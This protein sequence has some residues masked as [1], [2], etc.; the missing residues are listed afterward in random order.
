MK[1]FTKLFA[2]CALCFL[3]NSVFAKIIYVNAANGAAAVKDGTTWANAY[4]DLQQALS[5]VTL[6]AGDEIWVA[7]GVYK[8][9]TILGA[10]ADNRDKTFVLKEGVKV[11]GGF[12][13]DGTETSIG[14]R[15]NISTINET[16]LSGDF[17][18]D[19]VVAFDV[20]GTVSSITGNAENAHHVV[21]SFHHTAATVLDGFTIKGGNADGIGTVT[22]NT[23][24]S[25]ARNAGG[26]VFIRKSS[27]TLNNLV[28]K[29][30]HALVTGS[31]INIDG[32]KQN[33]TP[34]SADD[35]MV[36]NTILEYNW[37]SDVGTGYGGSTGAGLSIVGVANYLFNVTLANLTFNGN[38]AG[39]IGGALRVRSNVNVTVTGTTFSNNKS[40]YGAG[41][42]VQT[43]SSTPL[44]VTGS[45]FVK[46]NALTRGGAIEGNSAAHVKFESTDFI[47]NIA[48]TGGAIYCIATA[49]NPAKFTIIGCS[50]TKNSSTSSVATNGGGAIYGSTGTEFKINGNSQFKENSAVNYGGAIYIATTDSY[51]DVDRAVFDSNT[52]LA[53]GAIYL[54]ANNAAN[55]IN[56]AIFY[57]NSAGNG[58]AF[59]FAGAPALITNSTFY[60]NISTAAGGAIRLTNSTASIATMHNTII[61]GNIAV[62]AGT[63]DISL[64]GASAVATITNS[65]TQGVTGTNVVT[66]A[67]ATDVFLSIDPLNT[68]FLKLKPITGN[69]AIDSGDDSK[70]PAGV[71]TDLAGLSRTNGTVDMGAYE[72]FNTLPIKLLDFTAKAKNNAVQVNWLTETETDNDYFL[73]EKSADGINFN[74]LTKTFSKGNTG[75]S[76]SYTDYSPLSGTS[77]YR[78]T[79]VDKDGTKISFNPVVVNLSLGNQ[80]LVNVYPNPAIGGK[81]K[82]NLAGNRFATLQVVNLNGQI[83]QSVNIVANETEKIIDISRYARGVYFIKLTDGKNILNKKIINP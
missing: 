24:F 62:T 43:N 38:W 67:T 45:S 82:V 66:N 30:N 33:E 64:A 58:G 71:T 80:S 69:P 9:S 28:I 47:E 61:L 37:G 19:D 50:F 6:V 23:D 68:D 78:L 12:S 5:D 25:F 59:T 16:I 17:S 65:L 20:N 10:G 83:L 74:L 46:N 73:I 77:Y 41:I 13:G 56:N 11:Y 2:L 39:G 60:G 49:A 7:K 27:P 54:N 44:N 63:A 3:T 21:V 31:A 14:D 48:G 53:A 1:T 32:G 72:N 35:L 18:N 15:V 75:F 57:K 29:A 51:M 22:V 26:G 70:I 34:T 8:P 4:I 76:Y 55:V 42:Y 36:R 52:A 40:R 81:I 79:Q